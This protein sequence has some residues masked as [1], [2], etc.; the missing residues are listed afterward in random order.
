LD[1]LNTSSINSSK[2]NNNLVG[3]NLTKG[4]SFV[5]SPIS[6]NFDLKKRINEKNSVYS[7]SQWKKDF[8]RSR[9]Y[10]KISCEYPTI[11]FVAKPKRKIKHN[12]IFSPTKDFNIFSGIRFKPFE[13]FQEEENSKGSKSKSLSRKKKKRRNLILLHKY[14]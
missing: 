12:F 14:K 2:K 8:K 1:N 13:S 5:E 10:K 3:T 9:V 4:N 7:I 6:G 11:N